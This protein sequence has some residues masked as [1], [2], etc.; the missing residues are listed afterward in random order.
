MKKYFF[1][2]GERAIG[3]EGLHPSQ[4]YVALSGLGSTEKQPNFGGL[5]PTEKNER[6]KYARSGGGVKFYYITHPN[7]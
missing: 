5:E 1:I 2:G 7:H 6:A 3:C 4:G